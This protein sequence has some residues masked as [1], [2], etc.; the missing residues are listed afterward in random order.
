VVNHFILKHKVK[1]DTVGKQQSSEALREAWG[2]G[3][4]GN[5]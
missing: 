1:G 2:L 3:V 5:A 4:M